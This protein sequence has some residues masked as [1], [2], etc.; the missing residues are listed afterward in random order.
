LT[1]VSATGLTPD[2]QWTPIGYLAANGGF[3]PIR[4]PIPTTVVAPDLT[5][6]RVA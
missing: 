5:Y 4:S 1:T 2:W 3:G 6:D